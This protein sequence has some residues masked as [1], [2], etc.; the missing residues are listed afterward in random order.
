MDKNLIMREAQK[1]AAKGM[2]DKALE[3]WKKYLSDSPND[4]VAY[5]TVGDLYLKKGAR[6]DAVIAFKTAAEIF[7][8]EGFHLK[9]MAVYKKVI[10]LEPNEPD[11]LAA[12]GELEATRGFI[13]SA[14]EYLSKSA[15]LYSGK[16]DTIGATKVYQR[17]AEINPRDG[18]L[19]TR[20]AEALFK[21]GRSSEGV[22]CYLEAANAYETAGNDSAAE[23]VYARLV[24]VAPHSLD[25]VKALARRL[26]LQGKTAEAVAR[27][28]PIITPDVSDAALLSSYG[29][30]CLA[31]GLVDDA[32]GAASRALKADPDSQSARKTLGCACFQ[33]G[34]IEDAVA[35][36]TPLLEEYREAQDWVNL[37]EVLQVWGANSPSNPDIHQRLHDV[38]IKLGMQ[39]EA[40]QELRVLG[41]LHYESG[42]LQKSLHIYEHL[43][44]YDPSDV[45]VAFRLEELKGKLG[46][47]ADTI[48]IIHD[49]SSGVLIPGEEEALLANIDTAPFELENFSAIAEFTPL[50][51]DDDAAGDISLDLPSD[52]G[53]G[54]AFNMEEFDLEIKP[55][56]TEQPSGISLA[57]DAE[58][59]APAA[60]ESESISF[61]AQGLEEISLP[62]SPG[63]PEEVLAENLDE[64]D[65]YVTQGLV[66]DA[67]RIY[68]K[69]LKLD[70]SNRR[71]AAAIA[72]LNN[73]A[74]VSLDLGRQGESFSVELD[75]DLLAGEPPAIELMSNEPWTGGDSD[76]AAGTG[77][78]AYPEAI[79]EGAEEGV[80]LFEVGE[81]SAEAI[82]PIPSVPAG[83]PPL[84]PEDTAL[85]EAFKDFREGINR[86]IDEGDAE[87]HYNLGIAYKEMD[88][89]E[90]AI[91]EFQLTAGS[92]DLAVSSYTML[93]FCH[94]ELGRFDEAIAELRKGLS[95]PGLKEEDRLAL[96]YETGEVYEKQGN[97]EEA[98]NSFEMLVKLNP[99]YRDVLARLANLKNIGISKPSTRNQRISYL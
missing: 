65:F 70:P 44:Q 8:Q 58:F 55:A 3:E 27:F 99:E 57:G 71:A 2:T 75:S 81:A 98:I 52:T 30:T 21:A 29:E 96:V 82:E 49:D 62:S 37:L 85:R 4:G 26:L 74:E 28:K 72:S 23:A 40:M 73:P 80:N 18:S 67:R 1:F 11:I 94:R 90:E 41:N 77:L 86:Q 78:E 31:A 53:G 64:A 92:P 36:V 34:R 35:Q 43:Y 33:A 50:T 16:G 61:S 76:V 51:T 69:V 22:G 83:G 95:I 87:T 91:S 10:T 48:S 79:I 9:A 32:I 12:I 89:L 68:E 39:Q 54:I 7:S 97:T 66:D 56:G 47:S 6:G 45:T 5:N 25:V 17:L 63:I 88:L 13:A 19:K 60:D 14:N 24:E 93:A 59:A 42:Q 20:L 46:D 38:Y 15:E 84:S